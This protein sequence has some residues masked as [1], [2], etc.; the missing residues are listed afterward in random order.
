MHRRNRLRKRRVDADN[1]DTLVIG[2]HDVPIFQT[3]FFFLIF[4]V[5]R[6]T[7]DAGGMALRARCSPEAQIPPFSSSFMILA[8]KDFLSWSF[9]ASPTR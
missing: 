3:Y 6:H 9:Y 2:M 4:L 8:A 7:L 5:L 1:C